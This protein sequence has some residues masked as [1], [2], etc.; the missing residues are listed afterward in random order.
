MSL[1]TR[2]EEFERPGE[3]PWLD[4]SDA[5]EAIQTRRQSGE[6]TD[7][8]AEMLRHWHRNGWLVLDVTVGEGVTDRVNRDVEALI[9]EH[10]VDSFESWKVKLQNMFGGSAAVAE[11]I[12]TPGILSWCESILGKRVRPFQ[13]L[14]MPIGSQIPPHADQVL[15]STHPEGYMVAA[16]IALEDVAPDSGPLLLWSGTHKLPYLSA[17]SVGIPAEGSAETKSQA[18]GERYYGANQ[19]R[20]EDGGFEPYRF[21]AKRGQVLLWHSNILHGGALV[22]RPDSTRRSL[23]VHY[24]A[25]DVHHYSDL[26]NRGCELPEVPPPAS[27]P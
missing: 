24:F 19:K 17:R 18:Y 5:D 6:L 13:T 9:E 3:L 16:W 20:I 23:I 14:N 26:F 7:Q 1:P 27:G 10:G 4:R 15:M 25:E 12:Q 22:T 2:Y 21:L 8:H 11:A